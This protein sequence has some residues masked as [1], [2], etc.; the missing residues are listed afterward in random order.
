MPIPAVCTSVL[1]GLWVSGVTVGR[2]FTGQELSE[3]IPKQVIP[4]IIHL[5]L[6]RKTMLY[7]SIIMSDASASDAP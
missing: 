4:T 7:E 1:D 2:M 3:V 6:D 5:A